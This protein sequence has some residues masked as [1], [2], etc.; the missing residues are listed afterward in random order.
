MFCTDCRTEGHAQLYSFEGS[1]STHMRG[2]ITFGSTSAS[3]EVCASCMELRRNDRKI[4]Y[5]SIEV[6]Y[7]E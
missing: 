3:N 7:G 1:K 6:K 5:N 2:K 4:G